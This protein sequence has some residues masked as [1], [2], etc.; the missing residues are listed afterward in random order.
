MLRTI[1]LHGHPL[2]ISLILFLATPLIHCSIFLSQFSLCSSSNIC[3]FPEV[4]DEESPFITIFK[5]VSQRHRTQRLL[6]AKRRSFRLSARNDAI[7]SM[8]WKGEQ[9]PSAENR[10]DAD[11]GCASVVSEMY[12]NA[13]NS[14][15]LLNELIAHD[16]LVCCALEHPLDAG[17]R[18]SS[19]SIEL[20]LRGAPD[21]LTCVAGC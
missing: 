12:C 20:I 4:E 9:S 3:T 8:I 15:S 1:L 16:Y 18:S 11:W 7:S 14:V 6:E 13:G 2:L 5:A 17:M 19:E 21:N 10:E